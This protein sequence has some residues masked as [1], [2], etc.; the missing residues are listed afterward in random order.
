MKKQLK[1]SSLLLLAFVLLFASCEKETEGISKVTKFAEFE[2]TGPEYYFLELGTAYSEPGV[3]AFEGGDEITVTTTGTVDETQ[4]GVYTINYSATNSD[5]FSK[6]I[7]RTV[8]VYDGDLTATDL[9]GNYFGGYY[10][11]ANMSVSKVKDGLY[12]CTDVFG[13]GPPYPIPGKIV[14]IGQGNLIVLSTS[15]PFGPVLE[16]PGTYSATKLEY[17][18][19]IQGYGY[20]FTL[21][22]VLQ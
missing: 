21:E 22:W 18:L 17:T 7:T 12:E 20:I 4:T 19:G 15:S 14:D 8:V 3:K 9:S 10:G 2:M 5:G 6:S 11:D 16:T 1:Y 13:Y